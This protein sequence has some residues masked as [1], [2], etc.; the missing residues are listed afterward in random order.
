[1]FLGENVSCYTPL[2]AFV[3]KKL[4]ENG[5]KEIVFNF[6]VSQK[7][8]Y[9]EIKLPCGKCIG[10]RLDYSLEWA[11]R[12]FLE[13]LDHDDSWFVTFTYD[14][15]HLPLQEV[16]LLDVNGRVFDVIYNPLVPEDLQKFWKRLRRK[17]QKI[18]YFS[19]G[20]YGDKNFRPHYHA[21]IY[22]LKLLDL[23]YLFR[24]EN[25]LYYKSEYLSKIWGN[26]SVVIG[27][28]T[29]ECAAYTA[30]YMLKKVKGSNN[31]END[32]LY[33]YFR[34]LVS[35]LDAVA[36][37]LRDD[38]VKKVYFEE[39]RKENIKKLKDVYVNSFSRMSL[40]PA[41]GKKYFDENFQ[42][43]Y[44]YDKVSVKSGKDVINRVPFRYFD[45]LYDKIDPDKL[46]Q[47]KL[48]REAF[49]NKKIDDIEKKFNISYES[50]VREQFRIKRRSVKS[51]KRS[52]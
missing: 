31:D 14:D 45:K 27:R 35:A 28:F 21:I 2:K 47:L 52:L 38:V 5:K 39:F 18:R 6:P 42:K 3:S 37:A 1:M 8:L 40:K 44:M 29:W 9:K 33:D 24:K 16:E 50:Y 23:K 30:R 32:Y 22:G 46:I 4:K 20:E 41:I 25:I 7:H 51:L 13:S 11:G 49:I 12:C 17:G 19:C 26:G 36:K 15:L 48:I 10:C 34:G 43:I